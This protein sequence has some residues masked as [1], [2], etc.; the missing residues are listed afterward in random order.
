MRINDERRSID[1]VMKELVK[2]ISNNEQEKFEQLWKESLEIS[3]ANVAE[4]IRKEK[5]EAMEAA[6]QE[7]LRARGENVLTSEEKQYYTKL[8]E[9]FTSSNPKQA[10]NGIA[11]VKVEN[12]KMAT[13]HL[14]LD[15]LLALFTLK[16]VTI[17][18]AVV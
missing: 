3:E 9:A 12:N 2:A 14:D 10:W 4:R 6:D 17:T 18:S 7:V 1:Q 5:Q 15:R 16:P 8:G 13:V 11:H